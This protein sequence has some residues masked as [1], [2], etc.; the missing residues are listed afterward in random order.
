M[1]SDLK[2]L[3]FQS[4]IRVLATA[5]VLCCGP[6]SNAVADTTTQIYPGRPTINRGQLSRS[7]TN[8]SSLKRS[9]PR[10]NIAPT[11]N[12]YI[13]RYLKIEEANRKYESQLAQWEYRTSQASARQY[14]K[15]RSTRERE[16][17]NIQREAERRKKERE[18]AA[19]VAAKNAQQKKDTQKKDDQSKVKQQ[20]NEGSRSV[21]LIKDKNAA[22]EEGAETSEG[23]PK[24][25]TFWQ[26]IK[27]AIFG[28]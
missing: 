19:A 27:R 17:K 10:V 13:S 18:R 12:L 3:I 9:T 20:P 15:V 1:N 26:R 8:S 24:N 5:M 23:T 2:N 6:I 7:I 25:L 16:R 11:P 4:L 28:R 14:Q 21:N 22:G